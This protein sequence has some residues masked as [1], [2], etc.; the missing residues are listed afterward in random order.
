MNLIEITS[1]DK[2]I[3]FLH[4]K[5][6]LT[7]IYPPKGTL[8]YFPT[9]RL[10]YYVNLYLHKLTVNKKQCKSCLVTKLLNPIK[11]IFNFWHCTCL[12]FALQY[13]IIFNYFC[14]KVCDSA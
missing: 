8:E 12:L 13:G 2:C 4:S 6:R 1:L 5:N 14:Y 10:D 11:N 7:K 3:K 9:I